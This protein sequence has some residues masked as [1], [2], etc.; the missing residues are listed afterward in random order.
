MKSEIIIPSIIS[1]LY[2]QGKDTV[3]PK[4]NALNR[5]DYRIKDQN[6]TLEDQ[7]YFFSLAGNT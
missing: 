7:V 1:V 4:Y 6:V 5:L 3:F 2:M